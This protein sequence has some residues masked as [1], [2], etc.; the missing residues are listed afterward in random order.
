MPR[1][2]RGHPGPP[3]VTAV[4]VA[5]TAVAGTVVVRQAPAG[6][7]SPAIRYPNTAFRTPSPRT[8]KNA[9]RAT[10]TPPPRTTPAR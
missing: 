8:G 9:E 4:L 2:G 7:G 1:R 10:V 3:L 6:P 5:L